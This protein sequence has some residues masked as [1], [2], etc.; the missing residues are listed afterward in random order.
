MSVR[1]VE[2]PL[3]LTHLVSNPMFATDVIVGKS[4]AEVRNANWQ[5][6]LW[7][8]NAGAGIKTF[9]DVYAVYSFFLTVR[10]QETAFLLKDQNDFSIP[11]SGSTPQPIGTATG[12]QTAFQIFKSYDDGHSNT[13]QRTITR[14]SATAADLAVYD[15]GVLKTGGGVDY[16]YS[17]TT[18]IITFTSGRTAGHVISITLAKF[19]VPVRFAQDEFPMDMF[20]YSE[21]N[22]VR[23]LTSI[24]DIPLIEVRP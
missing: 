16:S 7:K 22:G 11:H 4:G 6:A 12:G 9:D 13:Y 20:L 24:P 10:G 2:L 17:T 15:A 1:A 18:G 5:D 8:F 19:Y 14:P 21:Q 3:A 23:T